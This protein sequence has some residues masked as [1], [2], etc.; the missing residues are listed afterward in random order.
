M[1][2]IV[3]NHKNKVSLQVQHVD[4]GSS[5]DLHFPNE[6]Q[7]FDAF[8]KLREIG[9]ELCASLDEFLSN[10]EHLYTRY[11]HSIPST[12]SECKSRKYFK[13]LSDKDLEDEDM[14]FGVGR[15]IAQVELELYILCQ[16]ILGIG[17]D[18]NKMGKWFWQSNKDRDLVILKNWVT[19]EK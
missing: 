18:A 3:L 7:S 2:V 8:Q 13:A 17:W 15:D 16:I 10:V 5:I 11:K 1:D 9:V 19:V 6:N 12:M 14:L 4:I